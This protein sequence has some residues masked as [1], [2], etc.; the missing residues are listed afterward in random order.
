MR[1]DQDEYDEIYEL[2]VR[3]E[4]M[5]AAYDEEGDIAVCDI[6]GAEM[7][8]DQGND[9]WYCPE[10]GQIMNRAIYFNHIGAEPPGADCLTNCCENYPFCKKI[11]DRYSI[12]PDDP[13]LT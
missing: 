11:C 2:D 10:C 5:N 4:W 12:D 3:D 13:M 1:N 8:W 9:E 7:R 6:C